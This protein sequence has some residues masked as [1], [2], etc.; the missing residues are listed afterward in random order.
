MS[1][2]SRETLSHLL[3]GRRKRGPRPGFKDR[4]IPVVGIVEREGSIKAWVRPDSKTMTIRPLV[5]EYVTMDSLVYTD[6][7]SHYA[8]LKR[9]GYQHSSVNHSAKVYVDGN[10]HTNTIEGFWMLLKNGIRGVYHAVGKDYL[11][12]YVDEY[13]FRY[14]HRKDETPMFTTMKARVNRVRSGSHGAY[15]PIG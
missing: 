8:L 12:T 14:N 13:T 9:D 3:G 15:A 7:A 1:V 4:K 6:D 2:V 11:Q 5:H 10:V